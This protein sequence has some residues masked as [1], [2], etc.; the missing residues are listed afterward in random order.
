MGGPEEESVIIELADTVLGAKDV[1]AL[2][3]YYEQLLGMQRV[4]E[5]DG[6]FIVLVDPRTQQRICVIPD[7]NRQPCAGFETDDLEAALQRITA[8]GGKVLRSE[9]AP[10]M[11]YADCADPNGHCFLIWHSK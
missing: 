5:G 8:L 2:A 11:D 6:S 7:P 10:R 1:E 4:K 9:K 3:R